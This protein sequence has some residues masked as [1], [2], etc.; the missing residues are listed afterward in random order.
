M[1][2]SPSRFRRTQSGSLTNTTHTESRKRYF[3]NPLSLGY[4]CVLFSKPQPLHP[5]LST[6]G[7]HYMIHRGSCTTSHPSTPN[8]TMQKPC[9]PATAYYSNAINPIQSV[10]SHPVVYPATKS[11]SNS[12]Y[13]RGSQEIIDRSGNGSFA[14][15]GRT[16]WILIQ[17]QRGSLRRS[18]EER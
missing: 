10:V 14:F 18:V 11:S 16:S 9:N 15:G 3:S 17:R 8:A 13:C 2:H 1:Y 12:R 7:T 6:L 4:L 5:R